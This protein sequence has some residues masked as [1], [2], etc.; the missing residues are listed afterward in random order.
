MRCREANCRLRTD[1]P[2]SGRH[3]H[4]FAA[5]MD[6]GNLPPAINRR[7][8]PFGP[9][10]VEVVPPALQC[11]KLRVRFART[12][13]TLSLH[14][15]LCLIQSRSGRNVLRN[16]LG[17]QSWL[18]DSTRHRMVT[19]AAGRNGR[20]DRQPSHIL[21]CEPDHRLTLDDELRPR[22][23]PHSKPEGGHNSK[24]MHQVLDRL[25]RVQQR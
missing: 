15:S 2:G 4:D 24:Q 22:V 3:I 13:K 17:H 23:P 20:D 8:F 12:S 1:K 10:T 9:V 25:E 16:S 11:C 18:F 6:K 19:A 14:P 7:H 5:P 21:N